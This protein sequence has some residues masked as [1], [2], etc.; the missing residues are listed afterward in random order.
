MLISTSLHFIATVLMYMDNDIPPI[1][2]AKCIVT[3]E[4]HCISSHSS[5]I[6]KDELTAF[7]AKMLVMFIAI[8]TELLVAI[9]AHKK[10]ALF[11]ARWCHNS[12]CHRVFQIIL[13]W[14]T[15]VFVQ[16]W[17]GLIC[18]PVCIVLLITPL[19]TISV[20]CATVGTFA[21]IA[22]TIMCLLQLG[23]QCYARTCKLV[24][25][26]TDTPV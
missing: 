2:L 22:A 24:N 6:Y 20:V 9:I 16:I 7:T 17:L 12:K 23:N 1:Q 14:N 21:S 10:T 5:S 18:L 13:L 4:T 26:N 15:F 19:Q 8:I 25:Y 3:S 11:T